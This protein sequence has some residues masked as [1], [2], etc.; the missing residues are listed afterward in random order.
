MKISDLTIYGKRATDVLKRGIALVSAGVLVMTFSGCSSKERIKGYNSNTHVY[1][2]SDT[3]I[4]LYWSNITDSDIE[5]LPMSITSLSLD[6]CGYVTS[7]DALPRVTPKMESLTLINCASITDLSFIYELHNLKY[8]ELNDI[9]GVSYELIEYLKDNGIEYVIEEKDIEANEIA[10]QIISEIITDDMTDE[11]KIRS[12]VVYV[13]RNCKYKFSK[14][15]E[16]NEDPLS[17]TLIDKKGV[18]FGIA[19]TTNVLLSKA[20]ITSYQV[21]STL[22]SWNLVELDGKYYYIDGTNLGGDGTLKYVASILLEHT[23]F[24]LNY[25]VDPKATSLTA[26]SDYDNIEKIVIP[27]SLI[28]DIENGEE[29]KNIFERYGTSIPVRII[30]LIIIIV[31]IKMGINK[32]KDIASKTRN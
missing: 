28:D 30:E 4:D 1:T 5:N 14:K 11:E 21:S 15:K 17:L 6:T 13:A 18:C 19:Y 3:E 26:M 2:D 27:Q 29:E 10:D 25:M 12:I 8:L 20:G 23:G 24:S 31:G 22:H 32:V 9:A 16:S 7:L